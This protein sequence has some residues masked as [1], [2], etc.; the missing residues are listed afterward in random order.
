ML[1]K[2]V[3]GT[4]STIQAKVQALLNDGWILNG[5]PFNTGNNIR[6]GGDPAYPITC[7]YTKEIGQSLLKITISKECQS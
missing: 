6:T 5:S 1:Y 4:T 3:T 2:I 7:E